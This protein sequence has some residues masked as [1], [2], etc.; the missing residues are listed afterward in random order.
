MAHELILGKLT[1]FISGKTLPDTI[2]ERARQKIARFLVENKGYDKS[3]IRPRRI[4]SLEIDGNSGVSIVDFLVAV[5]E[6]IV[7]ALIFGPGSLVSRERHALSA[8]MLAAPCIIP[9]AAVSNGEDLELLDTHTGKVIGKGF[10]ALFS[11]QEMLKRLP[12][13][14]FRVIDEDKRKKAERI[15][16]TI[17]VLTR[18][19][20][21]EFTCNR[22]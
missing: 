1:D 3:D 14:K 16:F 2:D 8:A 12:G 15:L 7:M 21:D 9:Y 4:I 17:D 10:D 11:K 19:E 6:K 20:C 5:D 22:C 18:R 13:L